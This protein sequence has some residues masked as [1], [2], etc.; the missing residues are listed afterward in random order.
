VGLEEALL[1]RDSARRQG[2]EGS[3]LRTLAAL[4]PKGCVLAALRGGEPPA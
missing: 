3:F 2:K 4:D 1:A